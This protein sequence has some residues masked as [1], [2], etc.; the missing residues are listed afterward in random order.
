MTERHCDRR[1]RHDMPRRRG[2]DARRPRVRLGWLVP[3][4]YI[5]FLMVP[6]YWL[7]TCRSRR[8][9]RSSAA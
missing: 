3:T 2:T 8:P 7:S 5:L 1:H 6:I 4:L 9:T